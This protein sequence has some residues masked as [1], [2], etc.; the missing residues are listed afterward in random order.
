MNVLYFLREF[1][2]GWIRVI[3][4]RVHEG[5]LWIDEMVKI[6][7]DIIHMVTSYPITNKVKSIRSAPRTET[8]KLVGE[9]WDGR[10]SEPMLLVTRYFN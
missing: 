7:K 5:K 10:G 1:K 9:K 8:K 3:L 6:T 4:S 2:L